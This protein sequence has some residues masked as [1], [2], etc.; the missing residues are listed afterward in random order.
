M[1]IQ[2]ILFALFAT[3]AVASA[4]GVVAMRDPI[5]SALCL[6]GTFF[7]LGSL[8]VLQRAELLGVLEVLVYAGAIMVLFVFVLML[9]INHDARR[10]APGGSA[11]LPFKVAA[12]S[13]IGGVF[14]LLV[15]E[16]GLPPAA[17]A[18]ADFGTAQ[19]LGHAFMGRFLFHFEM[20][21]VLLLVG[22]IGAVIVS[23]RFKGGRDDA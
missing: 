22:I 15:S 1:S 8:F 19:A 10:T 11:S 7:S 9:V 3:L 21:S 4:I 16:V 13:L 5:K 14:L 12:G 17:P 23:K 20:T 18:P 2:M 6:I